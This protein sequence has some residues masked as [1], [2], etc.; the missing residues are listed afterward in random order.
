MAAQ[1]VK[2]YVDEQFSP[3]TDISIEEEKSREHAPRQGS[4]K[5]K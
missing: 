5:P 1:A 2:L 3:Y 4:A